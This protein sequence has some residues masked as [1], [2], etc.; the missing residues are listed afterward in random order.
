M[1]GDSEVIQLGIVLNNFRVARHPAEIA[2]TPKTDTPQE[3]KEGLGAITPE[4]LQRYRLPNRGT[5]LQVL[6]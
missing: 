4:T 2:V 3:S 6:P 1:V 5:S